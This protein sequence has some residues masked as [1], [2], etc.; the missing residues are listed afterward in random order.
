MSENDET[1]F[2]FFKKDQSLTAVW[3]QAVYVGPLKTIRSKLAASR[4]TIA[5]RQTYFQRYLYTT[6]GRHF[7]MTSM[8]SR[9]LR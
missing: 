5:S 4:P 6:G 3:F 7:S 8:S 2:S 1:A 9:K